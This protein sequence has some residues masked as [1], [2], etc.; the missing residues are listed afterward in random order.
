[1]RAMSRP[2][3]KNSVWVDKSDP[4]VKREYEDIKKSIK[5]RG[6]LYRHFSWPLEADTP[7]E[8][9]RRSRT[10]SLCEMIHAVG[11]CFS[12]VFDYPSQVADGPDFS[13]LQQVPGVY[14]LTFD[15]C[16]YGESTRHR[17]RMINDN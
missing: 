14:F 8:V 4:G 12:I 13:R 15:G 5:A 10:V 11:D 16:K 7:E 6:V 17:Q 3:P 1:M 9:K 2:L